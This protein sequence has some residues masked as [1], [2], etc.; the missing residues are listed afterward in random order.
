MVLHIFQYLACI[1][2]A[3]QSLEFD[4]CQLRW[5]LYLHTNQCSKVQ[6][7]QTCSSANIKLDRW[8]CM[9]P[10]EVGA[11]GHQGWLHVSFVA[12]SSS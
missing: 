9:K 1:I 2:R 10:V 3:E 11:G 5:V 7:H 4:S 6:P 8:V 12:M